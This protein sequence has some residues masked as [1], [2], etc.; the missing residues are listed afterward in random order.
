MDNP[1]Y[2]DAKTSSAFAAV[3]KIT[4]KPGEN[5]TVASVYGRAD[6]IEQLNDL[7]EIVTAPSYI[8]N[9]FERARSLIN[10]LTVGVETTTAN[11][12]FDGTVKQMFLDNSLRGGMPTVMGEVDSDKTYDE[13][14]RVKIFHAFSRIHGDLERDYNAFKIEPAYFSQV[15]LRH[16]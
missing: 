6:D 15:R 5:V 11:P 4:L 13:D 10:E 2:G 12:L 9:K 7:A 14:D 8:E 16:C 3:R 1:Q